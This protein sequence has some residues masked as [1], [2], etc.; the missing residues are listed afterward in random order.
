MDVLIVGAGPVG[1]ALACELRRRGVQPRIVDRSAA[2]TDKSRALVVWPRTLELFQKLGID[3]TF[4]AAGHKLHGA[5][6]FG[7]GAS[8]S[9]ERSKLVHVS[10]DELRSPYPFGLAIPQSETE[11]LLEE[12]LVALGGQVEREVELSALEQLSNGVKAT[13]KHAAGDTETVEAAWLAACD[14]GHSACRHALGVYLEGETVPE[15]F[16]MADADLSGY[17]GADEV[18]AHFHPEGVVA[19]FPIAPPR[20]RVIALR[21]ECTP[22]GADPIPPTLEEMQQTL[23]QRNLGEIRLG[24]SYWL[25]A[26]RVNERYASNYIHGRVFLVGDAANVHSPIGGQGMNIGIQDAFNLA[27][28]L[29]LVVQG[30]AGFE[31]LL[32]SYSTERAKI[33]AQVVNETAAARRAI[34]LRSPVA[35]AIRNRVMGFVGGFEVIK[36][37]LRDQVSELAID[38]PDSPLNKEVHQNGPTW[39]ATRG[40]HPGDRLPDGEL[41]SPAGAHSTLFDLLTGT[42][43]QLLCLTGQSEPDLSGLKESAQWARRVASDL[44]DTHWIDVENRIGLKGPSIWLDTEGSL[45]RSL[46]ASEPSLYL[47]R[48]DGYVAF[49]CQPPGREALED[50]LKGIGLIFTSS[51]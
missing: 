9:S 41:T 11:R 47:I 40:V 45:H 31:P 34:T 39:M 16:A 4:L 37:R 2:R 26:F 19:I 50:Y 21:P 8:G 10:F 15:E 25:T 36:Q 18:Q 24:A 33:G 42:R 29:S 3:Q 46:G 23:D 27:W 30:K 5:S 17:E 43:F 22:A 38:Y 35:Q 44:I 48:P 7:Y 49:R 1:L 13:L 12:K 20:Y 32:S 51:D 28:K 6:I 14:G